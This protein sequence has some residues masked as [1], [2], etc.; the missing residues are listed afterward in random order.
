VHLPFGPAYAAMK[1]TLARGPDGST[2]NGED[3]TDGKDCVH[4]AVKP[5]IIDGKKPK[6]K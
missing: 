3:K 5:D 4:G 2:S 6:F 1:A